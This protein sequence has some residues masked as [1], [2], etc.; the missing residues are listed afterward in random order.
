LALINTY[1]DLLRVDAGAK[2]L[3]TT[4]I[5]PDDLV[6]QVFSI[7]EPLAA[8]NGMRLILR[9]NAAMVAILGDESLISG[10]IL[11]LVGN[12]TKYGAP[13]TD[14]VV[15]CHRDEGEVVIAV[16]NQGVG[17]SANDIPRIFDRYY[18]APEAER[19][20]TG[21]GLGLAFV[22]RIAEKHGGRIAVQ[23]RSTD[24]TFEIRLPDATTAVAEEKAV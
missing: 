20:V 19:T 11:N 4:V 8:E 17:I 1:L 14:I 23:S 24:T 18:R 16:E 10:A 6:K 22:K 2:P 15:S 13:G 5:D 12:A 3:Q 7:L 9:R 21:W